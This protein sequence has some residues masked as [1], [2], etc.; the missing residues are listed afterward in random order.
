MRPNLK[1]ALTIAV[2]LWAFSPFS[3]L[4]AAEN[5]PVAA[6][7]V[8][9][10]ESS[11][12]PVGD[13]LTVIELFSS[14]ACVFCPQAD[15]LFSELI[16]QPHVI[17][18]ACHVDYFDVRSGS[19]SQPFCTARQDWY[20]QVLAAGP[21]YTPQLVINGV[22]ETVGYKAADVR[23]GL[24][25]VREAAGPLRMD[26]ISGVAPG[27]FT[28][29]WPEISELQTKEPI[30][31]WL[32]VFDKPHNLIIGEGRNKGTQMRYE[33]IISR[34]QELGG[35]IPAEKNKAIQVKLEPGHK[36]FAVLAQGQNSGHLYAAGQ[37]IAP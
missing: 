18:L 20:M 9:A 6:N 2:F 19:L 37:Y 26:I 14:Q 35:W 16:L 22:R 29:S 1:P 3:G 33:N 32:S 13:Q 10:V 5:P 34:Q 17:G 8:V 27:E 4:V 25:K 28:I 11:A 36:G 7:P 21:N 15:A 23:N 31:L 30:V 12:L 24:Q